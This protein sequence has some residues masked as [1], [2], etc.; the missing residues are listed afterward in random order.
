M[1]ATLYKTILPDSRYQIINV[2]QYQSYDA[3]VDSQNDPAY[4]RKLE[5]DLNQASSIKLMRGFFRP[6]AY[7]AH[8][9]E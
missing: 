4:S 6:I 9:Y 1:T 2:S 8:T 3:F 7:C 5:A